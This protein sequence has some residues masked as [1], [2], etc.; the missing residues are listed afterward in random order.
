MATALYYGVGGA[1]ET[2]ESK[3]DKFTLDELR[4]K[5]GCQ[6]VALV[7]VGKERNVLAFCDEDGGPLNLQPN[8]QASFVTG[9]KLVGNVIVTDRSNVCL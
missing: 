6:T 4:E 8:V 2:I 7:A 3:G 1:F 5:I 9:R